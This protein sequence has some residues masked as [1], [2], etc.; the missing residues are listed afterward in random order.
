MAK[1]K[2]SEYTRSEQ[3]IISQDKKK[4][5]SIEEIKEHIRRVRDL[6]HKHQTE[7][8]REVKKMKQIPVNETPDIHIT[9]ES[10][11]QAIIQADDKISIEKA[12]LMLDWLHKKDALKQKNEEPLDVDVDLNL[13]SEYLIH[14]LEGIPDKT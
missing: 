10:T 3:S 14:K 1:Q 9:E 2:T 5:K 4:G 7:P 8:P 12:K 13:S 11:E 6:N